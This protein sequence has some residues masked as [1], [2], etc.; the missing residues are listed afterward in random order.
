MHLNFSLDPL[1]LATGCSEDSLCSV[2]TDFATS[3]GMS[4]EASPIVRPDTDLM[5]ESDLNS[6]DTG[7]HSGCSITTTCIGGINATGSASTP[8]AVSE[9]EYFK[10]LAELV[11]ASLNRPGLLEGVNSSVLQVMIHQLHQLKEKSNVI[12]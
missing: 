6:V 1:S 2:T 10:E 3:L 9:N 4:A 5:S 12:C 8:Q 7:Q 11:Q